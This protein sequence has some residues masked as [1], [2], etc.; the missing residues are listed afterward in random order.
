[1]HAP[2]SRF[3]PEALLGLFDHRTPGSARTAGGDRAARP[4]L[5]KVD[6]G[7][8]LLDLWR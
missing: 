5:P 8:A 6:L 1:V 7:A 2:R 4:A 3:I